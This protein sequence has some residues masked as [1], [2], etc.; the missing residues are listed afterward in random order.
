[1]KTELINNTGLKAQIED[2]AVKTAAAKKLQAALRE[3]AIAF[4]YYPEQ[5]E[6]VINEENGD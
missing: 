6:I 3:Y 4:G 1:M 2:A 5:L